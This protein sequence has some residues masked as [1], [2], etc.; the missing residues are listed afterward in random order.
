[1]KKTL[2][3]ITAVLGV[4]LVTANSALAEDVEENAISFDNT[5]EIC[6]NHRMCNR[7]QHNCRRNYDNEDY[8][9]ICSNCGNSNC[10]QNC[11][12]DVTYASGAQTNICENCGS[13][14]CDR[15]CERRQM[16]QRGCHSNGRGQ[17]HHQC[18]K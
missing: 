15:N 10:Q 6:D 14:D 8:E 7:G 18:R 16:H 2:L 4:L 17:R 5:Q 11:Y 12:Q 9:I 1:M 3:T 13:E